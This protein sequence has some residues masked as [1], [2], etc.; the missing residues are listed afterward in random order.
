[1]S[2]HL[3]KFSQGVGTRNPLRI[4]PEDHAIDLWRPNS[5]FQVLFE[6]LALAD[7]AGTSNDKLESFTHSGAPDFNYS[8]SVVRGT[9]FT[10]S[11]RPT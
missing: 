8:N 2:G 11:L 1:M 5:A 7:E 4:L 3:V 6:Q 10:L 9:Y